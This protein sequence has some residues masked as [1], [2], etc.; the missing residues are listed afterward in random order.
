MRGP[1]LLLIAVAL[2]LGCNPSLEPPGPTPTDCATRAKPKVEVGSGREAFAAAS[3]GLAL[4]H[5]FQGGEHV[6]MAVRATSFG[7]GVVISYG[8][9]DASGSPVSQSGLQSAGLLKHGEIAGLYGYL[10]EGVNYM[11]FLDKRLTLWA[12][13]TDGC[14]VPVRAEA[15]GVLHDS[16]G[17][18]GAGGGV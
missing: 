9:N 2:G 11:R 1:V 14:D 5:G 10:E 12:E 18:G 6:W 4:Q 13:V 15:S 8:I 7:P 17:S 16:E 3:E